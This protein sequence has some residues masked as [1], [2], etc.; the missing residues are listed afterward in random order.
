MKATT[1]TTRRNF[2]GAIM[3]GATVS[4]LSA[5]TN[6]AFAGMTDFT[7]S[8]MNDA[9]AWMKTIKG[10]HRIVYDGSY[11][12]NGFPIIWNWAY[13]LSNNEMGST[14]DEITAM[15]VLRHDAIPFALHDDL[16]KHIRSVKCSMLKKQ[17]EQYIA[18]IHT[19]NHRRAIFRYRPFK[20][21]KI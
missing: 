21:S 11:P 8:E 12:H 2:M 17:M 13:Y 14:D 15:T 1:A 6:P 19:T 16:G 18:V 7:H 10:K 4:T 5:F 20:E 3:L 9:E